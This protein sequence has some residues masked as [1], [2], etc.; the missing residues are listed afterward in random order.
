M[1]PGSYLFPGVNSGN[2]PYREC[3][4]S[5]HFLYGFLSN[6]GINMTVW[7]HFCFEAV[8][9]L[10]ASGDFATNSWDTPAGTRRL[11]VKVPAHA[12]FPVDTYAA[13][14][15]QASVLA[16]ELSCLAVNHC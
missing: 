6:S 5:L 3:I 16:T 15:P 1:L 10:L 14:K 8:T 7:L 9:W 2:M 12:S 11:G 13:H 4:S